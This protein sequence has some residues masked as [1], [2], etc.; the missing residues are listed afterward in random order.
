MY[1]LFGRGFYDWWA[2]LS[3]L[4]RVVVALV[5]LAASATAAFLFPDA[6]LIWGPALITGGVLLLAA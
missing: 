3:R 5:I 1:E 6:W 4:T 2:G